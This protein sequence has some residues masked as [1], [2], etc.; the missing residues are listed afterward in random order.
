MKEIV[1]DKTIRTQMV[2]HAA[3]LLGYLWGLWSDD[4]SLLGIA[5]VLSFSFLCRTIQSAW[6]QY[7]SVS[8]DIVTAGA[9]S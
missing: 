9:S 3:M 6:R 7:R 2:F 1:S 5:G 4:T 8:T